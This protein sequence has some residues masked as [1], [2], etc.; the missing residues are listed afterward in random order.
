MWFFNSLKKIKYPLQI[1]VTKKLDDDNEKREING[2]LEVMNEHNLK[3]GIILTED[4][5]EERR[6]E[7]KKI[8]IIPIWK[9]L[10]IES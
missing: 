3:E 7:D 8:K 10:L 9:W 6:I 1:Q 5:E 4:Q 2:L